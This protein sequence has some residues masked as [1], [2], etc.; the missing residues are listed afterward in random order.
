MHDSRGKI[1]LLNIEKLN[2]ANHT[3][4]VKT[5][6]KSLFFL[7][8]NGI[9]YDDVLLFVTDVAPYMSMAAR[10]LQF[11][12][13]KMIHLTFLVHDLHRVA[14]EIRSHF[15]NVDD[16]VAN[17]KNL[18]RKCPYRTQIFRAEALDL[19]LPLAPIITR[20][21]TWLIAPSYYFRHIIL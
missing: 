21:E 13:T 20:W 17:I 14:E 2:K 15:V 19:P 12:Y 8:S 16:L 5:F 9:Q 7:W 4:I 3:A 6:D 10:N 18:F 1:F 11:F